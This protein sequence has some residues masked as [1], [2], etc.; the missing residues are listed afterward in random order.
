[1]G[2]LTGT[3]VCLLVLIVALPAIAHA[4][5]VAVPALFSVLVFLAIASLFWPSRRRRR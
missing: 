2:R 5:Q 1:M 3:V 4:A